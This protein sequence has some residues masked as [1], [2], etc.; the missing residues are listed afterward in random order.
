METDVAVPFKITYI[1]SM[2]NA[3]EVFTLIGYMLLA[4]KD[5]NKS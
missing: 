5:T 1:S 2:L 3:I 4:N